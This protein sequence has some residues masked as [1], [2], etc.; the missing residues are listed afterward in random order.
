MVNTLEVRF[1]SNA[2]PGKPVIDFRLPLGSGPLSHALDLL[3]EEDTLIPGLLAVAAL[4]PSE[5]GI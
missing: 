4:P 2:A 3:P 5:R 1:G